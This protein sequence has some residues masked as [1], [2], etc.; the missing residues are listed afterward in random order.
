MPGTS[1]FLSYA[2]GD[3]EPFVRRLYEDLSAA[4]FDVWFDKEKMPS[5]GKPF[6][7]ELRE[8]IDDSTRFVLVVGPRVDSSDWCRAEWR[9]ADVFGRPIT[10]VIRLDGKSVDGTPIDGYELIPSELKFQELH[11]NDFR[12][13]ARYAENLRLLVD[14]LSERPSI[15]GKLIGIPA[16]PSHL[17]VRPERV[18]SVR[19]ALLTDFQRPIGITG[20]EGMGGLGKSV[21]AN[22]LA[23]DQRVRRTFK[24]G[25]FWVPIGIVPQEPRD[26]NDEVQRMLARQNRLASDL[27]YAGSPFEAV[28]EGR[29]GLAEL[30]ASKSVL[31]VLD[32]VWLRE[33]AEAFNVLGPKC[34]AIITTRDGSLITS[35]GGTHYQLEFLTETEALRI[36]A[37]SA[38]VDDNLLPNEAHDLVRCCGNLP[39]ALALCGGLIRNGMAWSSVLQGMV[40]AELESIDDSHPDLARPHHRSIASALDPFGAPRVVALFSHCLNLFPRSLFHDVKFSGLEQ[41]GTYR[42]SGGLIP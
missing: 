7:A 31:L 28:E 29:R 41:F 33:T 15:P 13:D 8:A 24:D 9:H 22:L 2:R 12:E 11:A 3:D 36:L 35:L 4:C 40:D 17:L 30:L 16:L 26:T 42:P 32:D 38:G 27:G 25:I 5:R 6:P 18:A 39:L 10:P 19:D 20:I 21:L 34:R 23:R 14:Q 37:Q 1:L